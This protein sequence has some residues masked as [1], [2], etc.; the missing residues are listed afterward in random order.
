MSSGIFPFGSLGPLAVVFWLLQLGLIVHVL[1]T[2]RPYWWIWILFVAPLIGGLAYV[3]VELSPDLRGARG[4]LAGLK[5][6]RW[7]ISDCRSRLE[8]ADTVRNR[9][10]LAAELADAGMAAEAHEVA[11]QCLQGVFRNDARTLVA[12]ARFKVAISAYEDALALLGRVDTTGDK[13]LSIDLGLLRGGCLAGLGRFPEAESAYEGVRD[14]CIGE[15][16]R[17]GLALAF[18]QAGRR[19]EAAAIWADIRAK[20]RATSPAWRRSERRWYKLAKARAREG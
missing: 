20:Y 2:G 4:L 18:E 10:D 14:R 8:E 1:R 13:M 19:G 9:L 16:A 15:A 17:A 12:V 7:R 3:L 5:P 6:R 11:A